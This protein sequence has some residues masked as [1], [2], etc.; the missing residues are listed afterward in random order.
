MPTYFIKNTEQLNSLVMQKISRGLLEYVSKKVVK[1]MQDNLAQSE[2]STSTLRDSVIYKINP[3]GNESDIYIWYE[4][5]QSFASS[6]MFDGS[7]QL[8]VWGHFTNTFGSNAYEQTWNGELIS[9]RLAEWL[10]SG[11]HGGIGNQPIVASHWFTKTKQEVE[12]NLQSWAREYL[13]QNG[14]VK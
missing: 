6:P 9:F 10:E 5:A 14:F 3:L 13:R 2:V 11:G 4:Y 8:V 1:I 7:G 12:T